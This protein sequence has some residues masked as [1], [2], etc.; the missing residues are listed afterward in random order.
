MSDQPSRVYWKSFEERDEDPAFLERAQA[1]FA[2]P[3]LLPENLSLSRR[4]F[5][6]NTSLATAKNSAGFVAPYSSMTLFLPRCTFFCSKPYSFVKI[7][8]QDE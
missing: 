5:E 3:P 8:A 6:K 7:L 1:E 2:K 4:G